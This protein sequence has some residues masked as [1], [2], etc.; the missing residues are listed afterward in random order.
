[1]NQVDS[2]RYWRHPHFP[3]LCMLK[4]H[5]TRHQ[6]ELHTHP[7][8]VIALITGGCERLRIGAR[9]VTAPA[10]TVLIVQPEECHDGE[11]GASDGW[12]YRTL[13]PSVALMADVARE[14]GREQ[15]PVF[16]HCVID[17]AVIAKAIGISHRIAESSDADDAEA[18]LIAA[19][20]SLIVR[21][22][23]GR[24]A[25]DVWRSGAAH[26]FAS[27]S[28]IISADVAVPL[29]LQSLADVAGVTRFQVIR[30]FKRV[31]GLTPGAWLRNRRLRYAGDLIR[32][33]MSAAE[34]ASTAGFA[35][36][37]HLSRTFKGTYGITP[38]TFA[39]A[40]RSL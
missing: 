32:Q 29:D 10:G 23:D 18:C 6:Y 37:S 31:T 14:L 38:A 27:Y 11:A 9:R 36:Q 30:D 28:D 35:D 21:H 17:D 12:S 4:A 8:Y 19:L 15:A 24:D 1:L 39:R 20:R 2:A 26:R 34:A 25:E 7:T 40:H 16:S 22:A 3:D 13:Y 5:F 33:G